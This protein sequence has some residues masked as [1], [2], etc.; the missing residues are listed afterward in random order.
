MSYRELRGE[1][2]LATGLPVHSNTMVTP[3]RDAFQ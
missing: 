3:A 1:N 2:M